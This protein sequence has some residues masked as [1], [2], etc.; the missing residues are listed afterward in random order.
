VIV[1]CCSKDYDI[2]SS[3]LGGDQCKHV[4][5]VYGVLNNK[6]HASRQ[7]SMFF[8]LL[9]PDTSDHRINLKLYLFCH[10]WAKTGHK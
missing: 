4:A 1:I 8:N 6:P 7:I 3:L 5:P 2:V 9:G 10:P